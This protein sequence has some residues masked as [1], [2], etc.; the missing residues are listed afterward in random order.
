MF[1]VKRISEYYAYAGMH[2]IS[3]LTDHGGACVHCL[4]AFHVKY[5]INIL[6]QQYAEFH[7]A[8]S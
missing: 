8:V 1:P 2:D 7:A 4:Y 6:M 5:A 3:L